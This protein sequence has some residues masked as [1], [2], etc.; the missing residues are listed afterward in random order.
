[1]KS[2][3]GGY[4][5]YFV[6][7]SLLNQPVAEVTSGGVYR[8]Y[9]YDQGG[10]QVAQQS[11]DGLFY[12]VQTDHLGSGRKVTDLSGNVVYRGEFDAH[13]QTLL[14]IGSVWT[15][16][17]KFTG[18]ERNWTTHVDYA[19]ARG[20]NRYRNRFLSPDPLGIGAPDPT[21]P[22][23]LNR[24][25]Y[26]GNDPI[27]NVDPS[28]LLAC[29][30]DGIESSCDMAFGMLGSGAGV[31]G[32]SDSTRWNSGLNGGKGGWENFAVD[33]NGAGHWERVETGLTI[34]GEN[35]SKDS[36]FYWITTRIIGSL[37][38]W[39]GGLAFESGGMIRNYRGHLIG[40]RPLA[41]E[42][43]GQLDS[44]G[45]GGFI[46]GSLRAIGP[47]AVAAGATARLT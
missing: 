33:A 10:R 28:G 11:S 16:T 8:A 34:N 44:V 21:N 4:P 6:W 25:S 41:M 18:Y 37:T 39:D 17:N 26:I 15:I 31:I 42:M 12:W 19:K 32:P 2:I 46:K 9:V 14:E 3:S 1:M 29:Y 23:S 43:L 47:A 40:D 7:S 5:L 13:G 20:Y 27:N 36:D 38:I 24:Y 22:Q 35:G 30:I 45:P